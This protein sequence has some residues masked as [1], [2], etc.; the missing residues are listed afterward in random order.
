MTRERPIVPETALADAFLRALIAWAP[1]GAR[2][3][4]IALPA[5]TFDPDELRPVV[6]ALVCARA[7]ARQ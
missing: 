1:R 4:R 7:E 3:R 6:V 2:D 5:G